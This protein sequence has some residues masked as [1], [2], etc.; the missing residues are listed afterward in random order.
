MF[1][2]TLK[3]DN[4]KGPQ[5]HSLTCSQCSERRFH[6]HGTVKYLVLELFNL[7]MF[8]IKR[9]YNLQCDC[10]HCQQHVGQ[11]QQLNALKRDLIPWSYFAVKHIG[12][13]LFVVLATLMF[14]QYNAQAK[15]QAY[16]N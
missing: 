13:L 15:A 9:Q 4:V 12:L 14:N 16:G 8:V 3:S 11:S 1:F 10:G 6:L 7:P 2:T 5:I